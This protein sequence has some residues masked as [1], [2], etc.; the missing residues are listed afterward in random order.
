MGKLVI[1]H[2]RNGGCYITRIFRDGDDIQTFKARLN[3]GVGL[4]EDDL[5]GKHRQLAVNLSDVSAIEIIDD[6]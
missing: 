4:F 2:M 1:L 6:V 5:W 3:G